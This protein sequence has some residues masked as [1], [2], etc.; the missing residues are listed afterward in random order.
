[1][2]CYRDLVQRWYC[3][4][5]E[6]YRDA[7]LNELSDWATTKITKRRQ[8]SVNWI[9]CAIDRVMGLTDFNHLARGWFRRKALEG[10][11]QEL[12]YPVGEVSSWQRPN[13]LSQGE[14]PVPVRC[15]RCGARGHNRNS[16]RETIPQ[17]KA[18]TGYSEQEHYYS[19][20]EH[21]YSQQAMPFSFEAV[22]LND[23]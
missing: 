23:P 2:E 17:K 14:E 1:M 8:K 19:E 7:P 20:Q 15:G 3:E 18:K 4:R 22:D 9:V 13:Y 16:C 5:W 11:Y 21:Y 10:T 12:V 6:K